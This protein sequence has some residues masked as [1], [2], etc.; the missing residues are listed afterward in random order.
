MIY[1]VLKPHFIYCTMVLVVLHRCVIV[2][3]LKTN[4][5]P[6]FCITIEPF[7]AIAIDV[8]QFKL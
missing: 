3:M 5:A 1:G 2:S 8:Y 7:T 6:F 4:H